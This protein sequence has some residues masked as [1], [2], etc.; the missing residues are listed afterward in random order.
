MI[1]FF[2]IFILIFR[3]GRQAGKFLRISDVLKW[4]F[5]LNQIIYDRYSHVY[6]L[7][8]IF[9]IF[10]DFSWRHFLKIGNIRGG[11]NMLRVTYTNLPR[12]IAKNP[13]HI[14]RNGRRLVPVTYFG[15]STVTYFKFST[16]KFKNIFTTLY[17]ETWF[18]FWIFLF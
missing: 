14:L 10:D 12:K 15:N 6:S 5:S 16:V 9:Y 11:A 17:N 18:Y 13:L 8:N 7:G 2:D 4:F 3:S 1:L